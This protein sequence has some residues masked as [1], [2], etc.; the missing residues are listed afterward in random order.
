MPENIFASFAISGQG[1]S[2]QRMRLSAVANNIANA[3]TTKGVDGKPYKRE[4]VVVRAIPGSPFEEKVH[5]QIE[6]KRTSPDHA[7]NAR[8]G[9]YP[10]DYSVLKARTARDN[11]PDRLVY[12]PTHPD[13]DEQGYVHYPNVNIV[14]EMVEMIS[15]QRGFEANTG[16]IT[17]AK[18]VA[19]NS[20]EI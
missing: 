7:P 20:L 12:D 3:N 17:A 5:Q 2:V 19:R 18:N 1:M 16:V 10:P 14:T 15:A 8:M 4:V 11:S 6:L 9:T 13:A